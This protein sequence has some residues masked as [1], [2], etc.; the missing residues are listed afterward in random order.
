KPANQRNALGL[1][2]ATTD[3][4]T[5]TGEEDIR[6]Q[7]SELLLRAYNRPASERQITLLMQDMR[8][9]ASAETRKGNRFDASGSCD[10]NEIWGEVLEDDRLERALYDPAGMKR[11]WS[12]VVH[13]VL[14]SFWYLHD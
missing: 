7:V 11:A 2:E 12:M 9:Y 10:L 4:T 14:N 3:F 13:S 8:D 6:R 5:T 1:V